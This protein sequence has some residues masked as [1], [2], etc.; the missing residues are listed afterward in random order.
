MVLQ[1]LIETPGIIDLFWVSRGPFLPRVDQQNLRQTGLRLVLQTAPEIQ[2]P[3]NEYLSVIHLTFLITL[4]NLTNL[5][6]ITLSHNLRW[7][8]H[9]ATTALILFVS[10]SHL[11]LPH[12]PSPRFWHIAHCG[13][14]K[15]VKWVNQ[16]KQLVVGR[17]PSRWFISRRQTETAPDSSTWRYLLPWV[18]SQLPCISFGHPWQSGGPPRN[19]WTDLLHCTPQSAQSHCSTYSEYPTFSCA[20]TYEFSIHS[21]LRMCVLEIANM[22]FIRYLQYSYPHNHRWLELFLI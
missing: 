20:P 5:P 15:G 11:P 8:S 22:I 18:K 3:C 12:C 17:K 7:Q 4:S 9:L 19:G 14:C 10:I 16:S 21:D 2:I 1:K 6:R 13:R